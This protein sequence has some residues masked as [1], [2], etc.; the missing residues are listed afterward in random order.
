MI[1]DQLLRVDYFCENPEDV[2]V[3][4]PAYLLNEVE[5]YEAQNVCPDF[6]QVQARIIN[7][8]IQDIDSLVKCHIRRIKHPLSEFIENNKEFNTI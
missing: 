5:G 3:P 2:N 6:D 4:G 1:A 8:W 7:H